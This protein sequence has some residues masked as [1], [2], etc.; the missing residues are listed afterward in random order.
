[1]ATST[2]N[3]E[4]RIA[5]EDG[6]QFE[7]TD[8]ANTYVLANIEPGGGG[9]EWTPGGREQRFDT[10]QG[11]MVAPMLGN[12]KPTMVK[13]RCRLTSDVNSSDSIN[14]LLMAEGTGGLCKEYTLVVRYYTNRGAATGVTVTFANATFVFGTNPCKAGGAWDTLEAEFSCRIKKPTIAAF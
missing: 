5:F 1:M 4:N 8:G 3:T 6:G 11:T 7:I 13:I 9:L 2:I 12:D 10:D 14:A